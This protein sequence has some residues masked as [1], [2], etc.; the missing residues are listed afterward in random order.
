MEK[1]ALI[2]AHGQPSD[3]DPA[4]ADLAIV[5]AAVARLLPGWRIG[6]ATLAAPDALAKAVA[7]LGAPLV[8][9]FFMADGWFIRTALPRKLSEAGAEDLQILP[10]FGL[11]DA[12][13]RLAGYAAIDAVKDQGW[14]AA[15]TVVVLAAHGS[16]RSPYPAEAARAVQTAL[17]PLG[18]ADLRLGFIEEEPSL[19]R[20]AT[21]AGARA[22]CLPLFVARWGHV[23]GDIPEALAAA[24]FQGL[25]LAPLGLRPEVPE[26]LANALRNAEAL[27]TS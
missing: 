5:A 19:A 4:E 18:F 26:I 3:P 27:G 15:Q 24:D 13:R 12:V 21:N 22:I 23:I 9:P 7:C 17:A 14:E 10:P 8:L 16:G 11:M 25:C 1:S 2:V 20:A 6:S